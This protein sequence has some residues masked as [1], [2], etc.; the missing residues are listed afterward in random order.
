LQL[1]ASDQAVQIGA[2]LRKR[3]AELGLTRRQLSQRM[4]G[5]A[6]ENDLYRWESGKHR[7][8]DDTLSAIARALDRDYA[9]ALGLSPDET[10]A[11]VEWDDALEERIIQ[12]LGELEEQIRLLRAELVVRD[13]EVQ[14]QIA[15]GV[16]TIQASLHQPPQ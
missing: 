16:R 13:A 5:L 8:Q 15:E 9:W 2:R 14:K 10:D 4:E 1:V 12:R 11:D 7:P 6:T 3:R